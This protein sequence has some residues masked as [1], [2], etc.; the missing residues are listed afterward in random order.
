MRLLISSTSAGVNL[1]FDPALASHLTGVDKS[2]IKDWFKVNMNIVAGAVTIACDPSGVTC[3]TRDGVLRGT[4]FR[5]RFGF[6][7]VKEYPKHGRIFFGD[8]GHPL[9]LGNG[10][11]NFTLPKIL[12]PHQDMVRKFRHIVRGYREEHE[13]LVPAARVFPVSRS[14]NLIMTVGDLT[15][16]YSVPEKELLE[17]TF[18]LAH[19]GYAVR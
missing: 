1:S 8:G 19:K 11:V 13:A 3:A 16:C 12:P 9:Y 7:R 15:L 17:L 6:G 10:I 14:S 5:C 18:S 4:A 2:E